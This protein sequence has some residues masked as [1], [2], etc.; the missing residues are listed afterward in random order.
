MVFVFFSIY[1]GRMHVGF[2]LNESYVILPSRAVL[3][4]V[5][6]FNERT[7]S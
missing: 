2:A 4:A 1:G 3:I 5:K 6:I 7:P